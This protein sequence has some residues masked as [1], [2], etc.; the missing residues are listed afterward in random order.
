VC[1]SPFLEDPFLED[2]LSYEGKG[3]KSYRLLEKTLLKTCK[4]PFGLL[5]S[6]RK[7]EIEIDTSYAAS[8]AAAERAISR[9][10]ALRFRAAGSVKAAAA[11][12]QH[13]L[14]AALPFKLS[15]A[16]RA[17]EKFERESQFTPGGR[18][19]S[20]ARRDGRPRGKNNRPRGKRGPQQRGQAPKREEPPG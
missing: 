16:R 12:E 8:V 18:K 15:K 13:L 11:C 10:E 7:E 14:D 2:L 1:E 17:A 4:A 6:L 20:T 9:L 5:M 19:S 3:K